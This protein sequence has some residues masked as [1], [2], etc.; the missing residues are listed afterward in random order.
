VPQ[1]GVR[2]PLQITGGPLYFPNAQHDT[3]IAAQLTWYPKLHTS[4]S[5]NGK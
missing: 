5:L 1:S 3:T 4:H 2:E